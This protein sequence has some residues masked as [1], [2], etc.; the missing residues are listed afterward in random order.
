MMAP[1]K[2][3]I[4]VNTKEFGNIYHIDDLTFD[5]DGICS[6]QFA[7]DLLKTYYASF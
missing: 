2:T 7:L 5:N 1:W 6:N 4:N 3:C